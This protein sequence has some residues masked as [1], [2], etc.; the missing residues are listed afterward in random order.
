VVTKYIGGELGY[1]AESRN[2]CRVVQMQLFVYIILTC[3]IIV[4]LH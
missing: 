1:S 4:S 3:I 2:Q